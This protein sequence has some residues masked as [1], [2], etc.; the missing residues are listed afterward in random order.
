MEKPVITLKVPEVIKDYTGLE[1]PDKVNIK[2]DEVA[3]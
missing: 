2:P 3:H 1:L